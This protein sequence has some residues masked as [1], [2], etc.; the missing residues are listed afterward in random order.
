MHS[1]RLVSTLCIPSTA[2]TLLMEGFDD[3]S[4][5]F[6]DPSLETT[7]PQQEFSYSALSLATMLS[8]KPSSLLRGAESRDLLDFS[9]CGSTGF[10]VRIFK[11]SILLLMAPKPKSIFDLL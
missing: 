4:T 1:A 11:L 9:L 6:T 3:L 8:S 10:E 5:T 7:E 2:L